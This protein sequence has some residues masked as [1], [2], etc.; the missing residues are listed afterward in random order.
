MSTET[1]AVDAVASARTEV[2]SD[3]TTV[4]RLTPVSDLPELLRVGE[5]SVWADT[6]EFTI[7]EMIKKGELRAVRFGR[8]LRVPRSELLKVRGWQ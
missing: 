3:I 7:R 8:L 6:S 2:A 4:T 1:P 5:C